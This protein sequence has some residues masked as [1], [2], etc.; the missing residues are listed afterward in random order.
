MAHIS[1]VVLPTG[2]TSK[3]IAVNCLK[4]LSRLYRFFFFSGQ[5]SAQNVGYNS[6]FGMVRTYTSTSPEMARFQ[7][8]GSLGVNY[9]TGM[10]GIAVPL[11]NVR[12]K[13][14]D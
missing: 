9:N 7:R 1:Y 2:R 6:S 14:H 11:V 8:H 10:P 12:L 5:L 4:K 13:D 3:I